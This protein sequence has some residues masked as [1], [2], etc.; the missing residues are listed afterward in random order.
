[1]RKIKLV[2]DSTSDLSKELIDQMCI[3]VVTLYVSIGHNQYRDGVEV[4][5]YELYDLVE[6]YNELPSTAAPSPEDYYNV[7]KTYIEQGYDVLVICI[8]SLMSASYQ[9]ATIAREMLL[10]GQVEIVD[11][12]NL[13]TGIGLLLLE[14]YD[15]CKKGYDITTV[16]DIVVELVVKCHSSFTIETFEYLQKGGRCS[17][18]TAA[19]GSM[20]K[21][22]PII[23]VSE[24][25]LVVGGKVR[26][27]YKAMDRMIEETLAHKERIL[28]N[29]LFIT[30]TTG[31]EKEAQYIKEKLKSKL[32]NLVVY[33]TYAGCVIASHCGKKTIGILFIEGE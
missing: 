31:S 22:K 20:L 1:M 29:R 23:K 25:S 11:S 2:T 12:K 26:G 24:G 32:E 27:K 17:G 10:E 14:A 21:I 5:E 4:K 13:S 7:Y 3:E 15:A 19:V 28:H 6:T 8:S 33:I 16:R 9:N 30:H 18:L